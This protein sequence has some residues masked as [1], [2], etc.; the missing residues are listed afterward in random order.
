MLLLS[1]VYSQRAKRGHRTLVLVISLMSICKPE[2]S[3]GISN[4]VLHLD[5]VDAAGVEEIDLNGTI[6]IEISVYP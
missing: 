3:L 2:T 4:D 6:A 1:R 5:M